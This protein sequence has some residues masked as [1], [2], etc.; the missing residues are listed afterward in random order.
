[1]LTTF[2]GVGRGDAPRPYNTAEKSGKSGGGGDDDAMMHEMKNYVG[3]INDMSTIEKFNMVRF[4][5]FIVF[6]GEYDVYPIWLPV[7]AGG[8][9]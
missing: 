4:V 9:W 2:N 6:T 5:G 8:C 3:I 1:M 7:D